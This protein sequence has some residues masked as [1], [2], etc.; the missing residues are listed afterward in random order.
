MRA[1]NKDWILFFDEGDALFGKRTTTQ[2]SND[3]FANQEISYLLQR[4]EDF[5][6][7]IILA[8]NFKNNIDPAFLRRFNALIYFPMPNAEERCRLWVKSMPENIQYENHINFKLLADKYELSGAAILN[9]IHYA[10]VKAV[11]NQTYCISEKDMLEGIRK[12]FA[13]EE[14]T[15]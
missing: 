1:E 6:G 8:S 2:S 9:I 13:K 3:K 7:L 5:P 11:A 10:S 14:R 4:V 12:E 15:I